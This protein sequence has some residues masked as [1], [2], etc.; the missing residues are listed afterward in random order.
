MIQRNDII[1]YAELNG[2]KWEENFPQSNVSNK[3]SFDSYEIGLELTPHA[4]FWWGTYYVEESDLEKLFF[5]HRYNRNTGG[6]IKGFLTGYKAE[7]KI[8][9]YLRNIVEHKNLEIMKKSVKTNMESAKSYKSFVGVALWTV[10]RCWKVDQWA[11]NL[12]NEEGETLW[13]N[14]KAGKSFNYTSDDIIVRCSA[15]ETYGVVIESTV[16]FQD[17]VRVPKG[18]VI[19]KKPHVAPKIEELDMERIQ[20]AVEQAYS[21][22]GEEPVVETKKDKI[23]RLLRTGMDFKDIVSETGADISYVRKLSKKI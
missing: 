13:G 2:L 7:H 11:Y 19:E 12:K 9:D 14:V 1:R 16:N 5:S 10:A 18:S 23:T 4:W 21:Q 6:V 15:G 3:K 22:G 8:E 20:G 17:G